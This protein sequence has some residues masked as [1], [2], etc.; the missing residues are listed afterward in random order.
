MS[1]ACARVLLAGFLLHAGCTQTEK[2]L[3][4]FGEPRVRDDRSFELEIAEP[5]AAGDAEVPAMRTL[6]P[7]TLADRNRDE[8]WDLSLAEAIR[9]ALRRTTALH[10]TAWSPFTAASR[11]RPSTSAAPSRR[12]TIISSCCS[13]RLAIIIDRG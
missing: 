10:L 1:A 11:R 5:D 12:S 4:Y 7:R 9:L 2:N 13:G 6:E 8:V 3:T